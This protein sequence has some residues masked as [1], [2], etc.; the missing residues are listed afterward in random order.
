MAEAQ[1]ILDNHEAKEPLFLYFAHQVQ[2]VPLQL[3]PGD[4]NKTSCAKIDSPENPDHRL[5]HTMCT[6]TSRLDGAIG[7][8]VSMVKAKG[9][10]ED[11]VM[12]VTTDNGGMTK[13]GSLL[14]EASVGCNYP[15]RTRLHARLHAH[16]CTNVCTHASGQGLRIRLLHSHLRTCRHTR[17]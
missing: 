1:R 16:V 13:W 6:M 11:T 12:W 4:F 2:H 8:F 10:W 3:P 9:M 14:E 17:P 7:D 5:R 15:L